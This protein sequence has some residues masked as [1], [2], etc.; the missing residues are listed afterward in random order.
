MSSESYS[1][2][3]TSVHSTVSKGYVVIVHDD[4]LLRGLWKLGRIQEVLTE[5]DKQPRTALVR[6]ASRDC[7]HV[8]F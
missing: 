4:T 6:V 1:T 2:K 3:K 7:Q 8:F 5:R